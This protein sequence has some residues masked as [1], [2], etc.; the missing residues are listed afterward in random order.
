MS[1]SKNPNSHLQCAYD[2]DLLALCPSR[3]DTQHLSFLTSKHPGRPVLG[4]AK[5]NQ[6]QSS[7][8]SGDLV[9][10]GRAQGIEGAPSLYL[11]HTPELTHLQAP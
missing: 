7:P 2:E 10:A 6:S 5:Q 4:M 11:G 3:Q 8:P 1:P 9:W